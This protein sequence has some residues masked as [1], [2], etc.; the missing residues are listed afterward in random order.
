MS[1]RRERLHEILV[2]A[3][4]STSVYFQPPE[5][6]IMRYPCI[7]YSLSGDEVK[8]ADNQTYLSRLEYDVTCISKQPDNTVASRLSMLPYFSFSRRYVK[9]NL[10]HDSLTVYF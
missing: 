10:Y 7:V 2:D 1:D 3:L 8:H 4:G 5:N 9:D 6:L